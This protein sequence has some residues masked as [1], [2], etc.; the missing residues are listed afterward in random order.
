MPG[1]EGP[2]GE[3][4]PDGLPGRRGDFGDK[5]EYGDVGEKG[6]RVILIFLKLCRIRNYINFMICRVIKDLEA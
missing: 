4:G 3:I 1:V 5:G 6:A 2:P